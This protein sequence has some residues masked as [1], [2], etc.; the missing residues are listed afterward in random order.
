M[1]LRGV[2][3]GVLFAVLAA[4]PAQAQNAALLD[5]EMAQAVLSGC[6]AHAEEQGQSQAVVVVDGG[7]HV[8]ASLRMDGN[9]P[10]V[11]AFA[12][13]K[14]YAAATWGFPTSG[15]EEGARSTP[16][17]ANAP[18][19]VTV[20]GGVPIYDSTGRYRL[21]AIGVSGEPPE[22]DIACAEAGIAAAGLQ[23]SRIRQ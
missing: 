10:G 23:P 3:G 9:G 11:I 17:F 18:G 13:E 4:L 8:M 22:D 16:G 2:T 6:V 21:G 20:G 19:V 14:A 12:E 15:M 5:A 1:K 7:G